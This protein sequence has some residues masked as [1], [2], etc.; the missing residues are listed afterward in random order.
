MPFSQ[1]FNV[2]LMRMFAHGFWRARLST[3][4]V[5]NIGLSKKKRYFDIDFVYAWCL[6]TAGHT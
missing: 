2:W 3:Q 1:S 6:S 4:T 5:M